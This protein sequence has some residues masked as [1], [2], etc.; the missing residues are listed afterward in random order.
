MPCRIAPGGRGNQTRRPM[1][2]QD[3]SLYIDCKLDRASNAR[4]DHC[5]AVLAEVTGVRILLDSN[6]S[7]AS[8]NGLLVLM[9]ARRLLRTRL[10]RFL[11]RRGMCLSQLPQ[12]GRTLRRQTLL[13]HPLPLPLPHFRDWVQPGLLCVVQVVLDGVAKDLYASRRMLNLASAFYAESSQSLNGCALCFICAREQSQPCQR[14]RIWKKSVVVL[15][16]PVS[17]QGC[18]QVVDSLSEKN[19][20][21][22]ATERVA[23]THVI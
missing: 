6:A 16:R 4:P 11:L 12:V 20:H 8:T 22:H 21:L 9:R 23:N 18:G 15:E 13:L 19:R 10:L 2:G 1:S 5:D 14:V 17:Q 3:R 7:Q